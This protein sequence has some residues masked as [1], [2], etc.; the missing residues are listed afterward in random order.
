MLELIGTTVLTAIIAVILNATMAVMP[1]SPVQKLT[2]VVIAGLWMG[3]AIALGTTGIYAATV[4]PVPV[5]GIMVALPL[6]VIGGAALL[7]TRVRDTLLALPVSL[8]L[9]LNALRILPGAFI[10]LLAS[11]GKLSG[12]FPQSAGWGDIIVGI[13]AIALMLAG[14]RNSAGSRRALLAWNILGT[15]D[16]VEAVAL[17]VLSAP[18]SPLQIY[19]G[20]IGSTAMWSLPWSSI[21]TLLVPF[22]FIT[23]GIIFARL[24]QG[25]RRTDAFAASQASL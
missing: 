5:V 3:L 2:T 23:H 22:Y 7:S 11:Q 16:L 15:L 24:L 21:P 17:G 12:P 8:L 6:V 13:I 19:G 25:T 4:T 14:T 9:G 20:A 1:M 18:G 10:L